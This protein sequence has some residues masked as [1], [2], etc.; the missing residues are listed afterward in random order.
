MENV[1]LEFTLENQDQ[2]LLAIISPSSK[3][4]APKLKKL[5]DT[6]LHSFST[7]SDAIRLARKSEVVPDM[8]LAMFIE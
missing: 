5:I 6:N 7:L 2:K 8:H 4:L 3:R 1:K